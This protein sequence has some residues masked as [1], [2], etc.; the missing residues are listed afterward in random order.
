MGLK[1]SPGL[2]LTLQGHFGEHNLTSLYTNP[3][4]FEARIC[5]ENKKTENQKLN[6]QIGERHIAH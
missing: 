4:C 5:F 3:F 2:S 6:L 1:L